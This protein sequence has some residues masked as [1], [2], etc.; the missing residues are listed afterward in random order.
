MSDGSNQDES[1]EFAQTEDS[2][3]SGGWQTRMD[4]LEARLATQQALLDQRL[5]RV[6]HNRLFKIWNAVNAAMARWGRR[7]GRFCRRELSRSTDTIESAYRIWVAHEQA[8]LPGPEECASAIAVW[9]RKPKF[10]FVLL[11]GPASGML[12]TSVRTQIYPA[13]EICMS[14]TGSR[15]V[16]SEANVRHANIADSAPEFEQLNAAASVA[17]GEYLVFAD[18]NGLL[19][20]HALY[21][22][23]AALQEITGDVLYA[24]E[25]RIDATGTRVQPF[26]R[27]GWS[28]ALLRSTM[29]MGRLIAVSRSLFFSVGGFRAQA[30]AAYLHDLMLRIA[31]LRPRVCHVPLVLFHSRAETPSAPSMCA[32]IPV[33]EVTAVTAV[34]CSRTA[35]LLR[36][37]LTALTA[38][39]DGVVRE[40]VVVAHEESGLNQGVREVARAANA[41]V[42]SYTGPFNFAAM[43]NIAAACA[44]TPVLL[45]LNDDVEPTR[46]G[47]AE[48]IVSNLQ[49]ADTGIAG[50]TLWYPDGS[51]QHAG[52]VSG[53][54]DGVAHAGR[55]TTSSSLWSWLLMS[56]NVSA[57]T[58]ACLAIRRE[59]FE[60][61]AGFDPLFPNNYNDVDLC[62]RARARGLEVV[63]VSTPGLVH[64]ECRTRRGIVHFAERYRFF[65]RWQQLL[66]RPDPYYSPSLAPSERIEL[67][68]STESSLIMSTAN[69]PGNLSCSLSDV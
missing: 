15:P 61:L 7:L 2:T 51:L 40:I 45:F 20:P 34:I 10:S 18:A 9:H 54:W 14:V 60:D 47:W 6:E 5:L 4:L 59:L 46:K 32:D 37:C 3:R 50:A 8:G 33:T 63:C 48:A 64:A 12:I 62:F 17:I 24:D 28:P 22:A 68:L 41:K 19:A 1:P 44:S 31:D 11:S 53:I 29:Y 58:G 13:W 49:A 35:A 38:T 39:A 66:S 55:G 25:D 42:L 21:F 65:R 69:S 30:G 43:N 36:K 27:P 57:V 56:R 52:I 26:F 23:A 16:R 67:N